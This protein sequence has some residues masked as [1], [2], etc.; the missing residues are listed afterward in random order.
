M[1]D[2]KEKIGALS[3]FFTQKHEYLC[4]DRRYAQTQGSRL[5]AQDARQKGE[6]SADGDL[7]VEVGGQ[8]ETAALSSKLKDKGQAPVDTQVGSLWEIQRVRQS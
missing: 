2:Y 1:T 5:K 6:S 4:W 7:R 3:P 8:V